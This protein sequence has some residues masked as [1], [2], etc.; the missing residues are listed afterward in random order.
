MK[1]NTLSENFG[2][3]RFEFKH[4]T[5]LLIILIAFQIILSIIQKTSLENF[6]D[7]TQNWYQRDSAERMANLNTTS[8]E[9]LVENLNSNV[10]KNE[11][12]RK[13]IIQSFNIIF[14]QQML[15]PN[16]KQT[17]LII[18]KKDVP[19]II[20]DGKVFYDF[21]NHRTDELLPVNSK[22]KKAADL[23]L[24]HKNELVKQEE[25]FS[26]LDNNQNFHILVPFVPHG[27]FIGVFY[28]KNK[29]DFKF[30]TEEILSSYDEVAII[31]TSL[32]VLG[33]LAMYYISSYTVKER[34]EAKTL[35]YEER[36]EHLKDQIDHNKEAMFTKRIY[37]THHKA[38]KVMGFI[39]EDL[40]HLTTENISSS[41]DKLN[42]YANFIS[43][44]IYDMKWY[45]PPIHT[46][47]NPIFST[48]INEVIKFIVDN[49]FLRISKSTNVFSFRLNLDKKIPSVKINEFVVWEILEPLIQ[50]CIDHAKVKNVVITISTKFDEEKRISYIE[51]RDNGIGINSELLKLNPEG[52]KRIFSESISTNDEISNRGYGCYIAHQMATKRCLW[53]IDADNTPE[54][55]AKFLLMIKN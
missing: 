26:I 40:R 29:P 13:K 51:I 10:E 27:E 54:G 41:K 23:F 53:N 17:C 45:D 42:K 30:I 47:R 28:M 49:L 52:V 31:Y 12:S 46:I 43:R 18:L 39:K 7:K 44:V 15:E 48:D 25:I 55:G 35:F 3:Y 50:N 14:S 21:L 36:E 4:L 32:I 19:F 9:L 38:E 22:F 6:L 16:V 11:E 37:H 1:K 5:V 20:N 8:L 24:E 33:L 34:D 2:R